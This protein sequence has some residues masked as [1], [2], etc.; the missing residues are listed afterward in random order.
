[1]EKWAGEAAAGSKLPLIH[2]AEDHSSRSLERNCPPVGRNPPTILRKITNSRTPVTFVA[3]VADVTAMASGGDQGNSGP[4]QP[5]PKPGRRRGLA[6]RGQ[7][8]RRVP[9]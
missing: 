9:V 1:M 3:P 7:G 8:R 4:H 2:G 5:P 6:G